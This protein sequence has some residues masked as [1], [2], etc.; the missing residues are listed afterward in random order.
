MWDSILGLRDYTLSQRQTLNRWATHASLRTPLHLKIIVTLKS[1]YLGGLVFMVLEIKVL[2]LIHFI[3][4]K[5]K[6]QE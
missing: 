2:K 5:D 1:L 4:F 6:L 3:Y